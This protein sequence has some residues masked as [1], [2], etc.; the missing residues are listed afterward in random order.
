M[1]ALTI[2]I[3]HCTEGS[4]SEQLGKEK[5]TQIGNYDVKLFLFR[6][7]MILY[8]KNPKESP[9]LELINKH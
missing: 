4:T 3:Q 7:D 8:I 9:K 6:D 1:S 5:G 2:S